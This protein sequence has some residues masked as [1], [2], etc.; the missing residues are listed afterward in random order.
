MFPDGAV[1]NEAAFMM[2]IG[3]NVPSESIEFRVEFSEDTS[4][5]FD[6]VVADNWNGMRG[7]RW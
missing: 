3:R 6:R 7:K 2:N 4:G 1:Q 5:K